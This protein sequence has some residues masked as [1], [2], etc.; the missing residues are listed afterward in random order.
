V[1]CTNKKH[2]ITKNEWE[3]CKNYFN[4]R[5]AYCGLA[6]EEHYIIYNGI[7][8]LGDFHRDHADDEGRN[9]LSNCIPA[10]KSC[11]TSKS[12]KDLLEWYD[13]DNDNFNTERLFKI[14]KWLNEDYL[15]YIK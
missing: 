3:N 13:V 4:Y 15:K 1:R 6:I 12:N 14:N 10:C 11:N 9:D 2:E 8:K 7:L 5:C